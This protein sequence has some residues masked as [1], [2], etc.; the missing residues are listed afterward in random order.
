M[1]VTDAKKIYDNIVPELSGFY[2]RI[3]C[4]NDIFSNLPPWKAVKKSGLFS[5]GEREMARL[6]AAKVLADEFSRLTFSEQVNISA[7]EQ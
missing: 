4:W 7:K 2:N 6:G 3:S 5:S 1:I